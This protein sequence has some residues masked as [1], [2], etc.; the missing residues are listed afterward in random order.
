MLKMNGTLKDID[1]PDS[2]RNN[3]SLTF[4]ISGTFLY[5]SLISAM[6]S[7]M[8]DFFAN[9]SRSLTSSTCIPFLDI[10]KYVFDAGLHNHRNRLVALVSYFSVFAHFKN[11]SYIRHVTTGSNPAY[12]KKSGNGNSMS[13]PSLLAFMVSAL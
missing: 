5:S 4:W 2:E 12:S 3:S 10:S 8:M 6:R 13:V 1:E 9:S 11:T 7:L